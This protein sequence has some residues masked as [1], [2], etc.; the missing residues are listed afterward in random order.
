MSEQDVTIARALTGDDVAESPERVAKGLA[1]AKA[2]VALI[3]CVTLF[4]AHIWAVLAVISAPLFTLFATHVHGAA[5]R[6]DKP[7]GE[8]ES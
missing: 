6:A 4:F 8:Q 2:Q 1:R 7:T 3:D 5:G